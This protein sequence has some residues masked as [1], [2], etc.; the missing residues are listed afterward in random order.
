MYC[1]R[2]EMHRVCKP[3]RAGLDCD[4]DWTKFDTAEAV[5]ARPP[6][7]LLGYQGVVHAVITASSGTPIFI[8]IHV[9]VPGQRFVLQQDH[10]PSLWAGAWFNASDDF[11][12]FVSGGRE[13]N[14][15]A[16]GERDLLRDPVE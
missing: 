4:R 7:T 14:L 10:L 12:R 11:V 2:G 9:P 15:S 13:K 16:R 5:L 3:S 1:V 6:T 8:A